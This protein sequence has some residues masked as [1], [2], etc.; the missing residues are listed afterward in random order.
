MKRFKV[1]EG[2]IVD[3]PEKY[4]DPT[5]IPETTQT[6]RTTLKADKTFDKR[7]IV[8][9]GKTSSIAKLVTTFQ[10]PWLMVQFVSQWVSNTPLTLLEIH[11]AIQVVSTKILYVCW[12]SKPLDV[13]DPITI[14]LRPFT[15]HCTSIGQKSDLSVEEGA[16]ERW[17]ESSMLYN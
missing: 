9:K 17:Q 2:L 1:M 12:R 14:V 13:Y 3:A 8:D 15:S 6:V 4:M 7:A 16:F 10:T 5:A 11:V